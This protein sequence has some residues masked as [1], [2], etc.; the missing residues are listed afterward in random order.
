MGVRETRPPPRKMQAD[1]GSTNGNLPWFIAHPLAYL[2]SI[3]SWPLSTRVSESV[4]SAWGLLPHSLVASD[5]A[6]HR[7]RENMGK[8][9][10]RRE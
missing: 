8:W 9:G 3:S 2:L 10:V 6:S 4:A 7:W 5:W 1:E